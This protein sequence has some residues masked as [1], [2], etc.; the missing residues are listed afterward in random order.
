[1]DDNFI[2]DSFY[3]ENYFC[4]KK[5]DILKLSIY[6]EMIYHDKNSKVV[7]ETK[8]LE[9]SY[10]ESRLQNILT[11]TVENVFHK[12]YFTHLPYFSHDIKI[13]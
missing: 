6:A 3:Y 7:F 13:V 8:E 12:D 9:L 11:L 2:A 1:M 5:H 4:L 10:L